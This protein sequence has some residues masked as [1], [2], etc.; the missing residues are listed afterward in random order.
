M[1]RVVRLSTLGAAELPSAAATWRGRAR[2]YKSV[3]VVSVNQNK[4][5]TEYGVILDGRLLK[6]PAQ[7]PFVVPS[8]LL[9]A[10]IGLEWE[11]QYGLIETSTMPVTMMCATVLDLDQYRRSETLAELLRY[12]TTDAVCFPRESDGKLRAKQEVLWTPLVNHVSKK[13][14]GMSIGNG[15]ELIPPV[16]PGPTVMAVRNRLNDLNAWH[17]H[18]VHEV[19][20]GSKS[21]V[22]PL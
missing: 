21:L 14:G 13:Y 1:N 7:S 3:D 17:V 15:E 6:T 18:A 12:F 16:H 5:L 20:K 22:I 4:S 19:A 2:F 8:R 9:A 11:S 10:A